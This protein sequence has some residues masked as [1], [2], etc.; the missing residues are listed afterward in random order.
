MKQL[1]L[2][3][4]AKSAWDDPQL[5]DFARPLAPRGRKAA[6]RMGRTMAARG[7]QPQRVLCSAAR[8]TWQTWELTAPELGG[9]PQVKSLRGLYLAS[10]AQILREIHRTP[11]TVERLMV[12][13]HNPGL[14]TLA[15]RLAGPDSGG[16]ELARLQEKFP[17]AAL[18]V[19]AVPLEQWRALTWSGA[20]LTA[21]LRPK[22]LD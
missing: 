4:H 7:W 15:R 2:Y 17:T 11:E 22:D 19:F 10:P 9:S 6:P 18:A 16:A 3:R 13:G 12:I 20:R 8:R 14:E 21:F 1:L 5:E